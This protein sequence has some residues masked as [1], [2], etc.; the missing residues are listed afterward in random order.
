MELAEYREKLDA[1]DAELTKLFCKRM[2]I[3]GEIGK[4]KKQNG[5]EILD[6]KREQEKIE[7]IEAYAGKEFAPYAKRV[8]ETIMECSRDYQN[9]PGG[10]SK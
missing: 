9:A 5:K 1:I 3:C 4:W 6:K 7:Q 2:E 8:Y 10:E